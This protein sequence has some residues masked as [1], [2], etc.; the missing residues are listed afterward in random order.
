MALR[1]LLFNSRTFFLSLLALMTSVELIISGS[2]DIFCFCTMKGEHLWLGLVGLLS[3]S[4]FLHPCITSVPHRETKFFLSI[5]VLQKEV[6]LGAHSLYQEMAAGFP[7]SEAHHKVICP[8]GAERNIKRSR[9]SYPEATDRQGQHIQAFTE[10]KLL[11]QWMLELW[12]D[13]YHQSLT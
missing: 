2:G 8:I 13:L 3:K 12:G 5:P 11:K 4:I 9:M 1:S 6:S 10:Q 7:K